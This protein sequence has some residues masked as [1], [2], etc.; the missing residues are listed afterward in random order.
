LSCL[1]LRLNI[2][3][4]ICQKKESRVQGSRIPP[5]FILCVPR[6]TLE[7]TREDWDHEYIMDLP[8]YEC[9]V[10][11]AEVKLERLL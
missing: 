10:C 5:S 8:C 2:I 9:R 7:V 3:K 11:L 4:R 1:V 6:R